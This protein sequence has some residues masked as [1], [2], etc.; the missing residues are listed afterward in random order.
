MLTRR[1]KILIT[2]VFLTAA[3]SFIT[4]SRAEENTAK[5]EIAAAGTPGVSF[6]GTHPEIGYII[7]ITLLSL[8]VA[9]L[10]DRDR[11]KEKGYNAAILELTRDQEQFFTHITAS[12]TSLE[13]KVGNLDSKFERTLT[14]AFRK[15][16][17]LTAEF[18]V[19][20]G[21]HKARKNICFPHNEDN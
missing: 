16:D 21:E 6:I 14:G 11:L 15:L 18:N 13:T 7:I 4:L 17:T 10:K 12:F 20:K 2:A 1:L 5:K 3:F 8:V 19:L 9:L